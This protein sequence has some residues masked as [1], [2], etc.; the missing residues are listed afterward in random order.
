MQAIEVFPDSD[1]EA[2]LQLNADGSLRHL[3]TLKGL[4]RS[5]LVELLDDAERFV[6]LPGGTAARSQSL[7]GRTVANLFSSQARERVL[8]LIWLAS[9]SEPMS[10]ISTSI[11]LREKRR[12]HSRHDLHAAGDACRHHGYS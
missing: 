6:S 9:A 8:R 12:E 7:T 10:S 4:D 3:L 1:N 11:P 5:L 2:N